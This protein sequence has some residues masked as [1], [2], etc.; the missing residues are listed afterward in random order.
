MAKIHDALA[1]NSN[2]LHL[3]YQLI[4]RKPTRA[5]HHW[6]VSSCDTDS[7]VDNSTQLTLANLPT[8]SLRFLNIHI[9]QNDS[10]F[11]SPVLPMA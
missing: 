8:G 11:L 2:N 9:H 3:V 4:K 5:E 10:L 7:T 6:R 1:S